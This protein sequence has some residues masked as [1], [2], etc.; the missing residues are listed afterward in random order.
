MK[1][2]KKEQEKAQKAFHTAMKVEGFR[3]RSVMREEIEAGAPG[4]RPFK[5]LR[6]ISG[7][8]TGR[9]KPLRRLKRLV[10]YKARRGRAPMVEV[11]FIPELITRGGWGHGKYSTWPQI[12][13]AQQTGFTISAGQVIRPI[14]R[15]ARR[16]GQYTGNFRTWA[17][18]RGIYLKKRGDPFARYYFIRKST[19]TFHIPPRPIIEPFWRAH[20]DEAWR[21]IRANWKRKMRG[22]RI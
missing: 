6:V 5:P 20:Q 13:R 2:L 14:K 17:I 19:T 9:I 12:I 22:E 11:G 1:G 3:L 10:R 7:G 4:G 8:R 16:G 15:A 18:R 21:N